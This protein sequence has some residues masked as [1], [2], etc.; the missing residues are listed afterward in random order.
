MR[1]TVHVEGDPPFIHFETKAAYALGLNRDEMRGFRQQYL[2]EGVHW[3][4]V[5]KRIYLTQ[6]GLD[7]I[8]QKKA[9]P[10]PASSL[11]SAG[12]GNVTHGAPARQLLLKAPFEG[13][14]IA[15]NAPANERILLCIFPQDDLRNPQTIVRVRV[16]TNRNFVQGMK[17]RARHMEGDLYDMAGNLPRWR[18]K[19]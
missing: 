17:V 8:L 6:E 7:L 14:L 19:Y 11:E 4:P 3:M 2:T 9:L 16:R 12:P 18:G 5:K 13:E 1:A 10:R 15:W